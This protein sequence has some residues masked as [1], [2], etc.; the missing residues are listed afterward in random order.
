VAPGVTSSGEFQ[1]VVRT[2]VER[3]ACL[4]LGVVH[5]DADHGTPGLGQPRAYGRSRGEVEHTCS[6]P[7]H[8]LPDQSLTGRACRSG[9]AGPFAVEAMSPNDIGRIGGLP[10][11]R[12]DGDRRRMVRLVS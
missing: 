9:L 10:R 1:V 2:C 8:P 4:D 7:R 12:D 3:G 5:I 6:R 11:R